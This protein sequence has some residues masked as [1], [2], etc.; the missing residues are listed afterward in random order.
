MRL[1]RFSVDSFIKSLNN[2]D[3]TSPDL[4]L[5][6]ALIGQ[7]ENILMQLDYYELT[8]LTLLD[9]QRNL[10]S[11]VSP[12]SHPFICNNRNLIKYPIERTWFRPSIQKRSPRL[13][14]S[15]KSL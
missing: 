4:P 11:L 8:S 2:H 14:R 10:L 9:Q 15:I 5:R 6:S 1:H 3:K 7:L 13:K 12:S